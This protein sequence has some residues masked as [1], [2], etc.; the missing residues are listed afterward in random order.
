MIRVDC[1]IP[2]AC[3]IY[4]WLFS[5]YTL[6][7]TVVYTLYMHLNMLI[8]NI[9]VR[10]REKSV[11]RCNDSSL[12]LKF[13]N[14]FPTDFRSLLSTSTLPVHFDYSIRNQ[15][16][17]SRTLWTIIYSEPSFTMWFIFE[18]RFTH[19]K[20]R[21][22]VSNYPLLLYCQYAYALLRNRWKKNVIFWN[23]TKISIF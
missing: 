8:L 21:H 10:R 23:F 22:D 18:P 9:Y 6:V 12:I 19:Q 2:Y 13:W 17:K 15:R 11:S 4:I 1:C 3:I 7:Y 16:E 5:T 14:E 20:M